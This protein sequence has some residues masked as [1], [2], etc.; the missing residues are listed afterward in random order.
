MWDSSIFARDEVLIGTH[1]VCVIGNCNGVTKKIA[2]INIYGPQESRQK[3]EIW[4]KLDSLMNSKEAIWILFGD[5]NVIRTCEERLGSNF[6]E[7]EARSFNNSIV[8]KGLEDLA[9]GGLRFKRFSSTDHG[10]LARGCNASFITLIP[11]K[12]DPLEVSNY[13]PISLNGSMYKILSKVLAARLSRVTHKM[14]GPNQ[15]AFLKGRQIL[16]GCVIA[17]EILNFAKSKKIN[18]L[19]FKVDFEKAFDSVN[20]EFLSNIM[21]QMNFGLK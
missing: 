8:N 4:L 6:V 18:M 12:A 10:S 7:R 11:K 9:I 19:L 16:D 20:W 3:E 15:T 5:F 2:V 17:N 14:I 21:S 1:Y 13:R